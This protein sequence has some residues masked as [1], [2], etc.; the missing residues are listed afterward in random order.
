M[1]SSTKVVPT[2]SNTQQSVQLPAYLQQAGQTAVD[3]ATA[4]SNTPYTPYSG[5]LVAPMQSNQTSAITQAAGDTTVGQDQ[6]NLADTALGAAGATAAAG[7]NAGVGALG[8]A[9]TLYNTA[10]SQAMDTV[11]A[12]AD[13]SSNDALLASLAGG[14]AATTTDAGQSD[15]DTA[16]AYNA[17]SVAPITSSQISSYMNPYVQMALDPQITALQ[18]QA[19][20]NQNASNEKAAMSGSFGGARTGVQNAEN[21]NDLLTQISAATGTGYQNAYNTALSA[22]EDA[23][24]RYG[25]A[26]NTSLS[27]A[28]GANTAANDAVSRLTS[29]AGAEGAAGTTASD[30]AT[31]AQNRLT[32][33]G[34]SQV[35]LGQ[36]QSQ[37]S[38]DDLNRILSLVAPANQTSTTENA[39]ADDS[40]NRLLTTGSVQQTTA[41]NQDNANYQQFQNQINWPVQQLDALL[42]AAG[43]VPYGTNTTSNTQGTQ[44]VQSPSI[45]G[46]LIGG[47][48]T[49]GGA[50]I[51]SN[52]D[53]KEDFGSVDDEDILDKFRRMPVETYRYREDVRDAI[54]DDGRRRVG[55]MAQ[56][57]GREFGGDGKVIPMPSLVG[58]L[59]SAVRALDK[60][61]ANSNDSEGALRA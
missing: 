1:G 38:T 58:A 50:A 4:I 28:A 34:Q 3:K 7:T 29:A 39:N 45:L 57:F 53:W 51:A 44:V 27:T 35:Q 19:A 32:S 52:R 12:G 36:A 42:A 18:K 17:D 49:V 25:T 14:S 55:P 31:A 24:N 20:I 10:G 61:T 6:T 59:V 54:G 47:A 33:A 22:A 40:L 21:E 43:G 15:L 5:Q 26:A 60:R 9:S 46:Q 30:L 11:N 13:S 37:L 41:Q 23:A 48:A 16:R 2:T 56:D 8:N